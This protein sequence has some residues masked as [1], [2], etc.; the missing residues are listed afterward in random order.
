MRQ[1]FRVLP[2]CAEAPGWLGAPSTLP[3]FEAT[4][5]CSGAGCASYNYYWDLPGKVEMKICHAMVAGAVTLSFA[6]VAAAQDLP[7]PDS[8]GFERIAEPRIGHEA[9]VRQ[10][11]IAVHKQGRVRTC[12]VA[13]APLRDAAAWIEDYRGFWETALESL[14]RYLEDGTD[15]KGDEDGGN[16]G[17][18]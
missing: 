3:A 16:Q 6:G 18:Q 2:C 13:A 14:A 8:G 15:D 17:S 1:P 7:V 10:A 5:L 11:L 9:L 4:T 12:A